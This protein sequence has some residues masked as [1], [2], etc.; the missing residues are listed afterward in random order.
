MMLG[1]IVDVYSKDFHTSI[2]NDPQQKLKSIEFEWNDI[3]VEFV[4]GPVFCAIQQK[5]QICYVANSTI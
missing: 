1:L 5:N 4:V 2:K 3:Y